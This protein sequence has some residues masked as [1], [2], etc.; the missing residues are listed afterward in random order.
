MRP[1][2]YEAMARDMD[3]LR[4]YAGVESLIVPRDEQGREIG[5]ELFYGGSVLPMDAS[6]HP[7][8]YQA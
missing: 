1:Q 7:G 3:D 4:R 2:H 6:L 8:A 5:T